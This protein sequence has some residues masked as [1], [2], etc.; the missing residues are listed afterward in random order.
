VRPQ[1]ARAAERPE[2]R[3]FQPMNNFH[4]ERVAEGDRVDVLI[5]EFNSPRLHDESNSVAKRLYNDIRD[6]GLRVAAV[7]GGHRDDLEAQLERYE[8]LLFSVIVCVGQLN[9]DGMHEATDD[10]GVTD[11]FDLAVD[12]IGYDPEQVILLGC[13]VLTVE[14]AQ[15]MFE[16]FD[17]LTDIYGTPTNTHPLTVADVAVVIVESLFDS[18]YA[19]GTL[20]TNHLFKLTNEVVVRIPREAAEDDDRS[21]RLEQ[22]LELMKPRWH[23]KREA[24]KDRFHGRPRW[25]R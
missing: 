5:L 9:Q 22:R 8:G 12:L 24:L 14:F 11:G 3:R 4:P 13:K 23:A 20:E 25:R 21:L 15:D 19:W 18:E 6:A 10:D 17:S 7:R 2:P 16:A 1:Q